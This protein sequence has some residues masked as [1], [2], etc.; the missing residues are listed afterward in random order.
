MIDRAV[1]ILT[2]LV[3]GQINGHP[4]NRIPGGRRGTTRSGMNDMETD[5]IPV[6]GYAPNFFTHFFDPDTQSTMARSFGV[7]DAHPA[8]YIL[9]DR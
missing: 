2:G 5:V 7:V 1:V 3:G 4:A 9:C 8:V 6:H